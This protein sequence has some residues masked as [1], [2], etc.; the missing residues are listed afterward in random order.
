[1]VVGLRAPAQALAGR[2]EFAA[3]TAADLRDGALRRLHRHRACASLS[4]TST[5]DPEEPVGTRYETR[6][7]LIVATS[8]SSNNLAGLQGRNGLRECAGRHRIYEGPGRGT[9][10]AMGASCS[11]PPPWATS[12]CQFDTMPDLHAQSALRKR[13]TRARQAVQDHRRR[14]RCHTRPCR[15]RVALDLVVQA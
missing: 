4:I 13:F 14:Q 6:G 9:S 3:A 12:I 11:G 8:I 5:T 10:C 2:I 1:E 7:Y 15:G